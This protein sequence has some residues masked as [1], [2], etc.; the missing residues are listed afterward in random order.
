[1]VPFIPTLHSLSSC[2]R[3]TNI[4]TSSICTPVLASF[5]Q[6]SIACSMKSRENAWTGTSHE[7]DVH[8]ITT[9]PCIVARRLYSVTQTSS[10]RQTDRHAHTSLT[11]IVSY[12]GTLF[13]F[14]LCRRTTSITPILSS[15]SDTSLSS[16]SRL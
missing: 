10:D 9:C 2:D 11:C 6:A 12:S 5:C 8:D 3:Q 1:M 4:Q 15:K 13:H 14:S 16:Y 7:M